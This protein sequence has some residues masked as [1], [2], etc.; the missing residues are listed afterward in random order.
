MNR[1]LHVRTSNPVAMAT[2]GDG[3]DKP[4]RRRRSLPE[5]SVSAPSKTSSSLW[6]PSRWRDA[7]R[8]RQLEAQSPFHPG[9]YRLFSAFC[10]CLYARFILLIID[11]FL[12]IAIV[13]MHVSYWFLS[14]I[15]C[16]LKLF[17]STFHIGSYRLFS[18]FSYILQHLYERLILGVINF[19][20]YSVV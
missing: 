4:I 14:I 11:Y 12:H 8:H 1:V 5:M 10:N 15:F 20:I 7:R 19:F 18:A 3:K 17:M 2:T 9:N 6:S 16:F 13:H